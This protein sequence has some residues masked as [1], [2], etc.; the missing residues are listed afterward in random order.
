[1]INLA[2]SSFADSLSVELSSIYAKEECVLVASPG[3]IEKK[4]AGNNIVLSLI[5]IERES[6]TGIKFN[7]HSEGDKYKKTSPGWQLNLYVLVAAVF[8]DKQYQ[9]GLQL[10][11]GTLS[12]IQKNNSY[13]IQGTDINIAVEPVN[14]SLSELSN[15]W[16]IC[17]GSYY[18][19]VLCKLRTLA[20]DSNRVRQYLSRVERIDR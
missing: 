10:L 19:S 11:S 15:L 1:M 8:S 6:T 4:G 12:F 17:G 18:P 13:R 16:S 14:L 5:N 9:D 2:L 20:M 3:N 7:Y